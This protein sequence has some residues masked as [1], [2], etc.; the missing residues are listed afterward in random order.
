MLIPKNS[1]IHPL[2]ADIISQ[3][4]RKRL[5]HLYSLHVHPGNTRNLFNAQGSNMKTGKGFEQLKKNSYVNFCLGGKNGSF[6]CYRQTTH[7]TGPDW[8]SFLTNLALS[9]SQYNTVFT[10][11]KTR[12][13]DDGN[14][15]L[16]IYH[17]FKK[18]ES[19][20]AQAIKACRRSRGIPPLI[21]NRGTRRKSVVNTAPRPLYPRERMTVTTE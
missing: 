16:Y 9:E 13:T 3:K 1:K 12:A 11:Q 14:F 2:N 10:L 19:V 15:Q 8:T 21:L 18:A 6:F 7:M 17:T 4:R 5:R 20:R